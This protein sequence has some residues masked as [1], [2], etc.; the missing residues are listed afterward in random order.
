MDTK[1]LEASHMFHFSSINV[2]GKTVLPGL[3]VIYNHLFGLLGV[4]CKVV[5]GTPRCLMRNH[6]LT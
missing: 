4:A 3:P 1:V 6:L 5:S 2:D